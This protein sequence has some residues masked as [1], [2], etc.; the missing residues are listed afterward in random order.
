MQVWGNE[1]PLIILSLLML[2][3]VCHAFKENMG[4]KCKK[5]AEGKQSV[6]QGLPK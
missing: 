5:D 1:C 2:S 6:K 3:C 4:L